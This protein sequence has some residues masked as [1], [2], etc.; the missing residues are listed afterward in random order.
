MSVSILWAK[1]T[2]VPLDGVGA[3]GTAVRVFG[4][5]EIAEW[6][7]VSLFRIME[8]RQPTLFDFWCYAKLGRVLRNVPSASEVKSYGG[9]SM[10][11]DLRSALSVARKYNLGTHVAALAVPQNGWFEIGLAGRHGHVTVM[12][13]GEHL[14]RF[15]ED[16]HAV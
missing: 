15:I 12:G 11:T 3:M 2:L 10:Y 8:S 14:S 16:I 7:T 4:F 5:E 1:S 6:E 9:L 13:D